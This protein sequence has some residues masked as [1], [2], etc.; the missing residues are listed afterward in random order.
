MKNKLKRIVLLCAMFTLIFTGCGKQASTTGAP[1]EEVINV[2]TSVSK[3]SDIITETTLSG[4]IKPIKE[5]NIVPKVSGEVINVYVKLGDKVTKGDLLFELDKIQMQNQVNQSRAIYNQQKSSYENAKTNF[6]RSKSL[7]KEGAISKQQ[8]E[9]YELQYTTA[10]QSF[11]QAKSTLDNSI[12]TLDNCSVTAPI[13]GYITLVDINEGEIASQAMTAVSIANI[14]TVE[15]ET[16][17]SE[18]LINKVTIGN[19]VK[20]IVRS[21][22][23]EKFIGTITELSPSPAKDSLTYPMKI[24]INNKDSIIKAGMFAEINI[25]SGRKEN[26]LSLPSDSV[27]IKDDKTIVCTVED[28]R[29]VYREV[30]TG[31]DNG[32]LIEI[33]E[34]LNENEVV[35]TK[36]QNYVD[37]GSKIN[38]VNNINYS[39]NTNTNDNVVD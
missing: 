37:N 21:A 33:T 3:K 36:G 38:V 9:N 8:Y 20:V 35:I 14:D 19:E 10:Y 25:V 39:T 5:S 4:R 1:P 26:V 31:L 12:D 34:G 2:E 29:V 13:S 23:D 7:Y 6:E 32:K 15:I 11:Q 30:S 27:I 17:I 16:S 28:N 18:Y 22:S 24:A